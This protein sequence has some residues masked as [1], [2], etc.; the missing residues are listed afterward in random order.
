MWGVGVPK[1]AQRTPL[2]ITAVLSRIVNLLERRHIR[3]CGEKE[4]GTAEGTCCSPRDAYLGVSAI[5]H[6]G[7]C[8]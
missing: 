6:S 1:R 4:L 5:G 8:F 2:W 3:M 7:V